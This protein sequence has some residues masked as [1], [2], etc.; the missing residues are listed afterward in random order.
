MNTE[1][2]VVVCGDGCC[3]TLYEAEQDARDMLTKHETFHRCFL[4]PP[5]AY[6]LGLSGHF[7]GLTQGHTTQNEAEAK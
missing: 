2:W 5:W 3:L 6:E 7:V 1:R 4:V